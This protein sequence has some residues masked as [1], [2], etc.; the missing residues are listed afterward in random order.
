MIDSSFIDVTGYG[1][2]IPR[3]P[4]GYMRP[5][6]EPEVDLNAILKNIRRLERG[7]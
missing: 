3:P 6:S 7:I 4:K 5:K 1:E 2:K